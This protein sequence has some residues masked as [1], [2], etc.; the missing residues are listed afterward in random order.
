[1]AK[2]RTGRGGQSGHL[3]LWRPW[4]A[5]W[6]LDFIPRGRE[7]TRSDLHFK[8]ITLAAA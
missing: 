2:G 6:S 7:E 5:L 1:M 8:K 3:E 4:E